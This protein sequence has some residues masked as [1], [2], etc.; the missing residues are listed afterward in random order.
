MKPRKF[1]LNNCLNINV[2]VLKIVDFNGKFVYDIHQSAL[3][4]S[5]KIKNMFEKNNYDNYD[6]YDNFDFK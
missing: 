4:D 5:M 3:E 2:I 6:N 1:R